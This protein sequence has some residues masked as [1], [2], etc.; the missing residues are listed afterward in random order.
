MNKEFLF[1]DGRCLCV[2]V[3]G[4]VGLGNGS[5]FFFFPDA[6]K[7]VGGVGFGNHHHIV[8]APPAHRLPKPWIVKGVVVFDVGSVFDRECGELIRWVTINK[9]PFGF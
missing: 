2:F 9:S 6:D 7:I 8:S 5:G 4:F 3:T 1:D